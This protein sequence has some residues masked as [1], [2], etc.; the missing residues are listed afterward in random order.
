MRQKTTNL[1]F[2]T[3]IHSKLYLLL[4]IFLVVGMTFF[5]AKEMMNKKVVDTEIGSLKGEIQQLEGSNTDLQKLVQYLG[6]DDYVKQEAKLKFGFQEQGEHAV[7]INDQNLDHKKF[8]AAVEK[9]EPPLTN[10]Q[11]WLQFIFH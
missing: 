3:L 5:L 2:R 11:K 1:F 4:G 8:L 7:V 9:T 6:S 10:P